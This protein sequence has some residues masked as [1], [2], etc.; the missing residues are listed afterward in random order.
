MVKQLLTEFVLELAMFD[1]NFDE[2]EKVDTTF[3]SKKG[4]RRKRD[5]IWRLSS[6]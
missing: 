5:V 2:M 6:R 4:A 3:H 1:F